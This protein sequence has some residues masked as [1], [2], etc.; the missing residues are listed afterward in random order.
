MPGVRRGVG[1]GHHGA[2]RAVQ[3]LGLVCDRLREEVVDGKFSV[4]RGFEERRQVRVQGR[5]QDG[6]EQVGK[7]VE[8]G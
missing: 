2:G 5:V 7:H 8:E 3:G 4:E 6:I 1:A